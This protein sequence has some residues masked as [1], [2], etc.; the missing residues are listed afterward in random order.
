MPPAQKDEGIR[1]AEHCPRQHPGMGVILLSQYADASYVRVL[2]A[3]G[4][5]RRGYLLKQRVADLEDLLQAVRD[6]AAGGCAL[7]PKV[8]ETLVRSKTLDSEGDIGRLTPRELE[9]LGAMAAGRTNSSIAQQLVLSTKA[10][11]KHIQLDLFQVWSDRRPAR[12]PSSPG[13][14]ALL[15][16][17]AG[18][19]V[20]AQEPELRAPVVD[21]QPHFRRAAARLI[22]A[23]DGFRLVGEASTGEEA[24]DM[25][26]TVGAEL[27]L[28]DVRMPGMG[29][30]EAARRILATLP[31]TRVVLVSSSDLKALPNAVMS[32]GAERF[33][34]KDELGA[35]TLA[36]LRSL[37]R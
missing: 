11:E 1:L 12:P 27:V 6:V 9:V 29:G 18:G 35:A 25:V 10:V 20:S 22:A 36:E 15:V 17:E 3:Q 13:G 26:G 8:V 4:T 16:G 32:C 33:L 30:V 7:D 14:A 5:Q 34:R 24:V 23:I 31:A 19:S 21:D 2:L 37:A 28:M